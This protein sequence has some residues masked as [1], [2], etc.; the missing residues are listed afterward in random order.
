MKQFI[1]GS[2]TIGCML[3]VLVSTSGCRHKVQYGD[4]TSIQTLSTDFSSTDLQQIAGAMV[5]S[6]LSFPLVVEMT[7]TARP[8]L[9]VAKVKNKTMQHIDTESITDSI[10]TKL[11]HT[12]KFRFV[13]RTTDEAVIEELAVQRE[14]G[15]VDPDKAT[16]MG[17][18]FGAEYLLTANISEIEQTDGR[19]KDVYY[20]FTMSLRNVRTGL[21]DWS[22]EKEMRKMRTRALIGM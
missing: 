14:S 20:K 2:A 21:I 3:G 22:D 11:L 13:D 15:L 18:Q 9:S 4:P 17:Q 10:R 7:A 16:P 1:I 8:V 5:D 19:V 12:G 6:L